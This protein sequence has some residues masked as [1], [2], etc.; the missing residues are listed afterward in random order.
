MSSLPAFFSA[1]P[2]R[3]MSPWSRGHVD[4]AVVAEEVGRVQHVDVQRVA[5]DPFA[6]IEQPA[7][8]AERPVDVMP[9]RVLHRVDG[10]HLIGDR[11]DAA[12]ARGDVRRLGVGAAAQERLEEPRRLEDL[13]LARRST[14][15]SRDRER[16]RALAL[17]PGEI[18]DLD[19]SYA[20]WRSLSLPERLG[21]PA[22]NVRKTRGDVALVHA[23]LA[24]ARRASDAV[25]G[26]PSARNSRSSRGRR[27]GRS[28][29][30]R[31][32]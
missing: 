25:L 10:A 4:R 31:H 2:R 8:R 18:V 29:R 15:P 20:P 23:E 1:S 11:A 24:P 5:L 26:S 32:G 7:Q 6:A 27:T 17:D 3:T 19:R 16:Q 28:R 12:D 14:A 13:Q 21:A 22:L 9:Q 30:S